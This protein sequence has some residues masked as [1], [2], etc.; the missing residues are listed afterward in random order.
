MRKLLLLSTFAALLATT[1]LAGAQ[2]SRFWNE[3]FCLSSK[4]SL[5][6][7]FHTWDQCI[8]ARSAWYRHPAGWRPLCTTNPSWHGA[9]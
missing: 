4:D 9:R 5:T 1:G 7:R 6:C 8:A 2:N 3:H